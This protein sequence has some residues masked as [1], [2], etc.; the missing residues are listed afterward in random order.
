MA[1]YLLDS[2][3]LLW[4][5]DQ[6]NLL[7]TKVLEEISK[8]ENEIIFSQISLLEIAIKQKIGKLP[9]VQIGTDLIFD[10]AIRDN[11]TFL[12]LKNSHI[13]AYSAISL[14]QSHRDP[15]DRLLVAQCFEER[16]TLISADPKRTLYHE[17]IKILW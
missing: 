1:K 17:F 2:H 10:Q 14:F 7:P 9:D 12:P 8:F 4:F 5:Q 16:A 15:F 3:V 11:F 13:N 6:S